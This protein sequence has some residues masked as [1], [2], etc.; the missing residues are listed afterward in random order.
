MAVSERAG[1]TAWVAVL[2]ALAVPGA[3]SAGG[4]ATVG[5]DPPRDT[6]RAGKP[7]DVGL[8]I[9]QHG[10]TPLVGVEP[11][12][13][14]RRAGRGGARTFAAKPTDRPGVYA[15]RVV[16]PAGGVWSYEVDDGFTARH[17]FGELR[18]ADR[19][20]TR[21]TTAGP[22]APGDGGPKRWTWPV[23]LAAVAAG[24]GAAGVASRWRRRPS[25]ALPG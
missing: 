9:R 10:R 14:I 7:W 3:A 24:L 15:A 1:M 21:A 2:V 23:L 19:A 16:F 17:S 5:L 4:W 6:L 18:V 12:V 20:T 11:R 22:G 8:T 25:A 13:L